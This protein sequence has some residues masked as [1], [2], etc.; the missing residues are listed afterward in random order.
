MTKQEFLAQ[1]QRALNGNIENK[2]AAAFMDY[3]QEYIEIE[4]RKGRLQ[5][6]ILEELGDPRLIAHSIIDASEHAGHGGAVSDAL[7]KY[8]KKLKDECISLCGKIF[9]RAR[10]WFENL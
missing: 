5:Q 7:F 6:D 8:G 1:L 9:E 10:K 2:E 4:M 3:Y